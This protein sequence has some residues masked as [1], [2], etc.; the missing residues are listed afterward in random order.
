MYEQFFKVLVTCFHGLVNIF[1]ILIE[2]IP[3]WMFFV[4]TPIMN[5]ESNINKNNR[6]R[7]SLFDIVRAMALKNDEVILYHD[8][9]GAFEVQNNSGYFLLIRKPMEKES[10]GIK[11][12]QPIH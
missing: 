12:S 7:L 10:N 8:K 4:Q 6:N 11:I 1:Y 9:T 2:E 3:M 5:N